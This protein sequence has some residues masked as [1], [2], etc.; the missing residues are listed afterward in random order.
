VF[1]VSSLLDTPRADSDVD[2]PHGK[3]AKALYKST[4]CTPTVVY[5]S[6]EVTTANRLFF[7]AWLALKQCMDR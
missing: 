1:K 7:L 3:I 5:I 6:G 2:L 4:T